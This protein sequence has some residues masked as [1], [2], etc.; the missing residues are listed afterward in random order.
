M[1]NHKVL[2]V[3]FSRTG[4]Q[5]GVG[6][7][8]EGNTAIVAKII[9]EKTNGDLFEIKVVK[10]N[11]PEGYNALTEYA[12][13]EM[14]EN[15]R[16]EII[17]EV[18]NFDQYDTIFIGFPVWWGDKPMPVYTFI[19]SYNFNDKNIV[20]FC[21]HEGSGFCGTQ[22]M[23]KTGARILK[24]LAMYGHVAQNEKAKAE[25]QVSNWLKAIGY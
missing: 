6:N 19:D 10:D 22:G 1:T 12:K 20:P 18:E 15:S 5:Y 2:V 11:Y 17:G 25:Q 7:I 4:E 23:D 21:T 9:A 8:T 3:Y 24:G 14:Q 13:T 16:P